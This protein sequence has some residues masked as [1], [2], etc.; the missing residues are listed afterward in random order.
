MSG[1]TQ[2]GKGYSVQGDRHCVTT[3][4][5]ECS[6]HQSSSGATMS[7]V[8]LNFIALNS[9]PTHSKNEDPNPGHDPFGFSLGKRVLDSIPIK[10]KQGA[11][12]QGRDL[13]KLGFC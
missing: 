2:T 5:P 8:Q 13:N 6:S 7:S 12:L 11:K 9:L 4:P 1:I 10:N 3:V